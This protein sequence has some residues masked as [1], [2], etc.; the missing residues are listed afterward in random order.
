VPLVQPLIGISAPVPTILRPIEPFNIG[1]P[2]KK[3]VAVDVNE[4]Q[5]PRFLSQLRP[6]TNAVTTSDAFATNGLVFISHASSQ[7]E[8]VGTNIYVYTNNVW[9]TVTN[10]VWKTNIIATPVA[11]T[12]TH[13]ISLSTPVD[14]VKLQWPGALPG[15]RAAGGTRHTL[16]MTGEGR[17]FG[18]GD[19]SSGALG[20]GLPTIFTGPKG[21]EIGQPAIDIAAGAWQSFALDADGRVWH[22][23]SP[24]GP[25]PPLPGIV[26]PDYTK[27]TAVPLS[28]TVSAI[29][30]GYGHALA[31][32]NDGQL[33]SWG[34]NLFG[35]LGLGHNQTV[36]DPQ[37]VRQS[38]FKAIAAGTYHS[39]GLDPNG[40]VL[41]WGQNTYG[42]LGRSGI[43]ERPVMIDGL[44]NVP[45][46]AL[47]A[48]ARH[49]LALDTNGNVWGWGTNDAGQLGPR[50]RATGLAPARI[51]G[52]PQVRAIRAGR[53]HNLALTAKGKVWFIGKDP[54][55]DIPVVARVDPLMNITMIAA[56]AR[57]SMALDA[58]GALFVWGANLPVVG[59]AGEPVK[60]SLVSKT[61]NVQTRTEYVFQTNIVQEEEIAQVA[62]STVV[63]NT[64]PFFRYSNSHF[65]DVVDYQQ[66]PVAPLVREP[67]P[68]PGKLQGVQGSLLYAETA[69][70]AAEMTLSALAYDG[71][72][73]HRVATL[74]VSTNRYEI[75]ANVAID[76]D[77]VIVV[78]WSNWEQG[79]GRLQ[80]WRLTDQAQ[81]S[82]LGSIALTNRTDALTLL[83]HL[84][85][86]HTDVGTRL[87]NFAQPTHPIALPVNAD[88]NCVWYDISRVSGDAETGV[89][90]PAGDFGS[91]LLS[92][93]VP[94]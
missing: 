67:V 41:S 81:F 68:L 80:C 78:A 84:A 48:G 61:T 54:Q 93:P 14:A 1:A 83:D 36:S 75:G 9:R 53:V 35:Q 43:A 11:V 6:G 44:T 2:P 3:L 91:L 19:N 47:A 49:S 38:R 37:L 31:L 92:P 55:A 70:G 76:P 20:P 34:M 24:S 10:L 28:G 17:L 71:V 82:L 7:W 13:V 15:S 73:A 69:D 21:I 45:F 56:G 4:P 22:W 87:V 85:V 58:S 88:L 46:C 39:L 59:G 60:L 50:E 42:Q 90:L 40:R 72:A 66:D 33:W 89:W 29:A 65:L 64:T 25:P 86:L 94:K 23:G 5:A 27:P 62:D 57:H 30:A 26:L 52:L 8:T 74:T 12:E 79:L 18:W 16:V 63:T 32:A 77:G 51:G